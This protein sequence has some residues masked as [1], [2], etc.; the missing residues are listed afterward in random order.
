MKNLF[1]GIDIK[2]TLLDLVSIVIALAIIFTLFWLQKWVQGI[3]NDKIDFGKM[4]AV[5]IINMGSGKY[6]SAN[7]GI[8]NGTTI[9]QFSKDEVH[10]Q[11][12]QIEKEDE[13]WAI[14]LV[15]TNYCLEIDGGSQE[16]GARAQLWNCVGAPQQTWRIERLEKGVYEIRPVHSDKCLEIGDSSSNEGAT[17]QQWDCAEV[18]GQRWQIYS[19]L[20]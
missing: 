5:R 2:K 6:L 18:V 1:K 14:K 13:G 12:W 4:G 7:Q 11:V 15:N 8:S 19:A 10:N 16:D 9:S 20:Y 3:G 17:V